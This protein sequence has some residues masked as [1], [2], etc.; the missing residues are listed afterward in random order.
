MRVLGRP[1]ASVCV[2]RRSSVV[3]VSHVVVYGLGFA[4][5]LGC[6]ALLLGE[7]GEHAREVAPVLGALGGV[8]ERAGPQLELV[9]E[10]RLA[11]LLGA[12]A[13]G[14]RRSAPC[15]SFAVAMVIV[16]SEAFRC[17]ARWTIRVSTGSLA[18]ASFSAC[19]ATSSVMP[20]IS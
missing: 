11:Q 3:A 8:V 15:S 14:R 5:R 4:R 12:A 17:S 18:C 7:H 1:R 9:L 19:M 10:Q 16:S 13:A 6:A 20:S 2:G